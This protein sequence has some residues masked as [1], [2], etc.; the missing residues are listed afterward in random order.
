MEPKESYLLTEEHLIRQDVS[1]RHDDNLSKLQDL[2][3]VGLK[4]II[5]M[6]DRTGG[7][8]VSLLERW[9]REVDR[10]GMTRSFRVL[11]PIQASTTIHNVRNIVV[12][13]LLDPALYPLTE[14]PLHC[15][16]STR[17]ETLLVKDGINISGPYFPNRP[18]ENARAKSEKSNNPFHRKQ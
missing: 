18:S 15:Y 4:P 6:S 11:Y 10:R 12:T 8:M 14:I 5:L 1:L 3:D 17:V 7:L 13:K 16:Q 2:L 9:C